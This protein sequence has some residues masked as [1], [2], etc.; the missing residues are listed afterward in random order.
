MGRSREAT[1][2]SFG[3]ALRELR[4]QFGDTESFSLPDR[5]LGFEEAEL[6]DGGSRV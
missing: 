6:N 1:K 3:G 4:R 2:N 5:A